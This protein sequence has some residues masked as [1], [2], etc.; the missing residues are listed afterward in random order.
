MLWAIQLKVIGYGLTLGLLAL[1]LSAAGVW[2]RVCIQFLWWAVV[3]QYSFSLFIHQSILNAI[4]HIT[5]QPKYI[6]TYHTTQK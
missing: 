6:Q 3:P 2:V 4:L 5:L 1:G